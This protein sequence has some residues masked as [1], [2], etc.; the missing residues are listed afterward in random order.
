MIKQSITMLVLGVALAFTS[1]ANAQ[2]FSGLDKSPAD[3]AIFRVERDAPPMVKVIYGRPMLKGR[4]VGEELATFGKVWR[5]GANEATEIKFYEDVL[6]GG[7]E[8]PAGTYSLFTIPGKDQWTVIINADT[9]IW[10]AYNYDPAKDVARIDV[11][12]KQGENSLEAFSITFEPTDE[13]ANML[14]GWDKLRVAVPIKP[15][16]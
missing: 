7:S 9:D 4:V 15:A 13:G 8:I 1:N 6:L 14:M 2:E 16:Q 11:P 12:A 10:G 3:I 5:T